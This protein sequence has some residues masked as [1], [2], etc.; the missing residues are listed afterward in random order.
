MSQANAVNISKLNVYAV[1]SDAAVAASKLN[2]YAVFNNFGV[3]TSKLNAYAVLKTAALV[4]TSFSPA[5]ITGTI[6]LSSSNLVAVAGASNS[7]VL[8]GDFFQSGLYYF[9]VTPL[10][11]VFGSC[12]VGIAP[13]GG[14]NVFLAGVAPNGGNI[15]ATGSVGVAI[16]T[17]PAGTPVCIAVNLNTGLIWFRNGAAGNWNN[18]ASANP[19]TGVGG[20]I[21]P[22][23]GG[24]VAPWVEFS[25]GDQVS[26]NAGDGNFVGAV[27][28][29]FTAGWPKS[30]AATS[31]VASQFGMETWGSGGITALYASQ[32]GME[33]WSASA[34]LSPSSLFASQLGMEVWA[35]SDLVVAPTASGGMLLM[36]GV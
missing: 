30:S 7:A 15:Y 12:T 5:L 14:T 29:G 17:V 21:L 24:F 31:M 22:S 28:A 4:Y 35:S 26:L 34:S 6:T 19:A 18:N 8:A 36:L 27:P 16:G 10:N 32:L 2:A 25:S 20:V 1:L 33:V 23:T 11:A 3:T 9:E 13:P